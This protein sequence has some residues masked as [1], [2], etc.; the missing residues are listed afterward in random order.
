LLVAIAACQDEKLQNQGCAHDQRSNV[1]DQ[2]LGFVRL[3]L[4]RKRIGNLRFY[5]VVLQGFRLIWVVIT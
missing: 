4:V 2:F 5:R 1:E 3:L